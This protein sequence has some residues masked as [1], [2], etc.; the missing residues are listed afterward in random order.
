MSGATPDRGITGF[1]GAGALAGALSALVFTAIHQWL[2]NPIWFALPVMILAG[3]LCGMCLAWSYALVIHTPTVGSWLRYNLLFLVMFVVLGLTSLIAFEPV[4]TIAALLQTNEPP[5]QLIG[6]A[7]PV[8]GLFTLATAA[9]LS[10]LYRPRWPG[11]GAILVTTV[12]LI[13]FLGLNISVL[14]LVAVPRSAQGVLAEVF[15]LLL[16]L[17]GIYAA[18]VVVLRRSRWR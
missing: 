6:H 9:L 18:G 15:A 8:T 3:G 10:L 16:A 7:L 5:R 13:L 11:V 2:I 1:V 14:G 12:V 17:S 4:T